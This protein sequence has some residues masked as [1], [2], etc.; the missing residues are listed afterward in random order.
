MKSDR[1]KTRTAS[2]SSDFSIGQSPQSL[3]HLYGTSSHWQKAFN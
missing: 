2:K 3:E 1:I